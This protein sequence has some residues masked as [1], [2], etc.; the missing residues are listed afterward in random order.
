MRLDTGAGAAGDVVQHQRNAGRVRDATEVRLDGGLRGSAVVRRHDQ[1]P[2]RAGLFG[3]LRQL[4]GVS[5]VRTADPRDERYAVADGFPDRAQQCGLLG[6]GGGRGLAGGSAEHQAVA[7]VGDEAGGMLPGCL[8]VQ[9]AVGGERSD[10]GAEGATEGATDAV[11]SE[12][13]DGGTVKVYLVLLGVKGKE[14]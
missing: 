12:V 11:M 5:G 2:V 4:H 14:R 6:A 1:Q 9:V 10:H 8:Q 13:S 7:A 3:L